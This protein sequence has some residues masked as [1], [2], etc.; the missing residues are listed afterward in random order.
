M[1]DDLIDLHCGRCGR[2]LRM[3]IED[4][5]ER[6]TIDCQ[7]FEESRERQ[8]PQA[9]AASGRAAPKAGAVRI[10]LVTV[11]RRRQSLSQSELGR[12]ERAIPRR[13]D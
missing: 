9:R 12:D 8:E 2:P 5:R 1:E 11:D 10:V 7:C 4:R 6:R 3:R 13:G